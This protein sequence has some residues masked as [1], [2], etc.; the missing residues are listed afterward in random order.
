ME[1]RI[2]IVGLCLLAVFALSAAVAASA[3]ATVEIG[4]CKKVM[5]G[6]KGFHGRYVGKKC[7]PGLAPPNGTGEEATPE[8]IGGGGKANKYEWEPGA[9]GSGTYLAKGKQVKIVKGGLEIE[10]KNSVVTAGAI[11]GAQTLEAKFNFKTCTQLKTTTKLKCGTHNKEPGEIESKNLL[12]TLSENV[13]KEPLIAYAHLKSGV[14]VPEEPWMEFECKQ[15]AYVISGTL[16]GKDTSEPNV[17]SKKSGIKFAEGLGEQGLIATF[18]NPLNEEETEKE[19][20]TVSF[21]Q[22]DKL[23]S[24]YELRQY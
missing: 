20:I 2:R 24:T 5:K 15:T 18:P 17:P 1:R 6:A 3:Q 19:S 16:T 11:K 23:E 13:A 12:G 21:E 7:A 14:A 4:K 22:G 9:G 10:C 8:E